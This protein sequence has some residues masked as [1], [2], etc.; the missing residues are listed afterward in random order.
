ME[1]CEMYDNGEAYAL[2]FPNQIRKEIAMKS[3]YILPREREKTVLCEISKGK[4]PY[5]SEGRRAWYADSRTG[6]VCICNSK[7]LVE[8]AGL[9]EAKKSENKIRKFRDRKSVV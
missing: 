5:D 7:G 3:N 6:S 1:K 9:I 4:C 8:K 2:Y